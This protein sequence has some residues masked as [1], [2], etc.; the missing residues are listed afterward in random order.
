MD[1]KGAI[2]RDKR[3]QTLF[4][5]ARAVAVKVSMN[6]M[7]RQVREKKLFVIMSRTSSSQTIKSL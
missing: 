2:S 6:N 3:T 5:A 1:T 7:T 4:S